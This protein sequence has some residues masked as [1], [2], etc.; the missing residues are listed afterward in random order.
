M[1][2]GG[3]NRLDTI[4][5]RGVLYQGLRKEIKHLATYKCDTI[6]DYDSLKIELRKIESD[7][8]IEQEDDRKKPCKAAVNPEKPPTSKETTDSSELA[9]IK[10][11]LEK[12]NSRIQ[13]LE[14]QASGKEEQQTWE[15]RADRGTRRGSS[16]QG[17]YRGN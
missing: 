1:K 6:I 12:L 11:I 8:T 16:Y 17:Y 15:L 9:E 14:D 10:G 13:K 5:L 7:I 2:L 4:T 3:I